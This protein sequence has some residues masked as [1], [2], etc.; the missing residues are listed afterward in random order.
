MSVAMMQTQTVLQKSQ[1]SQ[2]VKNAIY[3]VKASGALVDDDTI[4]L[5]IKVDTNQLSDDQ[6]I[7]KI[8]EDENLTVADV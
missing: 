6:A 1:L 8:M 7:L 5:M 2:N 4:D 3:A